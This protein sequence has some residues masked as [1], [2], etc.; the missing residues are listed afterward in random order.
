MLVMSKWFT[1]KN[2]S[3]LMGW[4][5][6]SGNLGSIF[7]SVPL[8]YWIGLAGWRFPF[9]SLGIC[10]LAVSFISFI[11][12]KK[13]SRLIQS[14]VHTEKKTASSHAKA[15]KNMLVILGEVCRKKTS[16]G[17]LLLPFCR[18]WH[19]YFFYRL[20]GRAIRH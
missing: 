18:C 17:R 19:L 11:I 7:A 14:S 3:G 2:F 6:M 9:F 5:G 20:L 13:G 10:L 12:L 4:I 8:A 15:G 1:A 16:M